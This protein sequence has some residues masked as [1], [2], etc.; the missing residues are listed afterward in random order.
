[1][2]TIDELLNQTGEKPLNSFSL[3]SDA[4]LTLLAGYSIRHLD[5]LLKATEGLNKLNYILT[6]PERCME[7]TDKLWFLI[8]PKGN[9]KQEIIGYYTEDRHHLYTTGET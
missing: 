4:E 1:M 9:R 6:V 5:D 8:D 7:I 2:S 3:F